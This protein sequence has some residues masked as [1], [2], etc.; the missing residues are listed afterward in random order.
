M[1]S[2]W[3]D[4]G[5]SVSELTSGRAFG[6]DNYAGIH[7]QVLEALVAGNAGHERP[8]GDDAVTK[9]FGQV[10]RRH[11]G[12][13]AEAFP[14]LN[15]TG[16]NVVALSSLLQRWEAVICSD[17]AHIHTDEGGAPEVT[18]GFKLHALP[19]VDGKLTP[20]LVESACVG[21]GF[22]HRAQQG[23]VSITQATEVGTLYTVEEIAAIAEVAHRHDLPLHLDG[24]RIA[25][26][27][28]ALGVSLR[29]MTTDA[30]V[31]IVSLGGTKNGAMLAE[32]VVVLAPE[33]ATGVEFL[34]K[35]HV[36]LTSKMRFVSAQ[37]VALFDGDLWLDNAR[38][39]NT[40]AQRLAGALR[41]VEGVRLSQAPEANGV[42]VV[43]P[44]AVA[45]RL[46]HRVPFYFWN[47]PIGEVRLMCSFDTSEAD[48]DE[49][50]A[51]VRE[52][53]GR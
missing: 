27:C 35:T 25:N 13:Q 4:D 9:R 7:P 37:L 49:F 31:D 11:F 2:E 5:V 29:E 21:V 12:E 17:A 23:A 14:M 43:M 40:M 42:F 26:A 44:G 3:K 28:A 33:R 47:E 24:A 46:M 30:G 36:Q 45:R 32:A 51:L 10:V 18:G 6:S 8:Y 20:D 50:V 15:G 1:E 53:L 39:A 52:E 41:G 19:T 48:V 22:V 38:H 16:A 34:R